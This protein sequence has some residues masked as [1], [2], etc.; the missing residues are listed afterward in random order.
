VAALGVENIP[1]AAVD[2]VLTLS[3]VKSNYS[4][5]P[6]PLELRYGDDGVLVP[7]L[8]EDRQVADK[9]RENAEPQARRQRKRDEVKT[10]REAEIDAA[11]IQCVT[12]MP[13]IGT[14]D[15]RLQVKARAG[16]GADAADT[17]IARMIQAGRVER[18][19]GKTKQHFLIGDANSTPPAS[20]TTPKNGAAYDPFDVLEQMNVA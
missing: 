14:S 19:D 20:G 3:V 5:K 7:L 16:C 10:R 1:E 11:V 6:A 2:T 18:R 17:A 15:L 9:A 12:R 8:D 13:G 4:K